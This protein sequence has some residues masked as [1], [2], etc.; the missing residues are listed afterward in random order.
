MYDP[1]AVEKV[2]KYK[3]ISLTALENCQGQSKTYTK[4]E[5]V[6]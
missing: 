1:L 2:S 3:E 4:M 5:I 6:H